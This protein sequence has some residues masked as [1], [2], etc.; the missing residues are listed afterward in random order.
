ME[1]SGKVLMIFG[2]V[3]IMIGLFLTFTQKLPFRLG[4]LPGDIAYEKNGVSVFI[5]ITTMIVIS[6]IISLVVWILGRFRR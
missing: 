2:L 3:L 6:A 5:P 1:S 4:S